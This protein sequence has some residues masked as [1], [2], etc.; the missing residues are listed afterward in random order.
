M[1]ANEMKNSTNSN[2]MHKNQN[3]QFVNLDTL[4]NRIKTEDEKNLRM[5]KS[6][7]WIYII[8][9]AVYLFLIIVNP[10]P[11]ISLI[12]RLSGL[13]YIASMAVFALIFRKGYRVFKS[14]DYGLPVLEMLRSAAKRYRLSTKNYL[15][16]AIPVI[17]MDIGLTL[18]FYN[19]LLPLAPLNRVLIIQVFYIPIMTISGFIGY[20]IWRKQQKPLRDRAL[21]LIRELEGE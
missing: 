1:K 5:S 18:S 11:D 16:I 15:I 9:V 8:L 13:F 14:I 19:N 21:E 3:G 12:R 2:S 4:I 6:F 17:L 10:D 20:Y 7:L